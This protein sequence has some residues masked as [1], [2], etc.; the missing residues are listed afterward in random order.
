MH[1]RRFRKAFALLAPAVLPVIT[2]LFCTAHLV[3]AASTQPLS[4]LWFAGSVPDPT[5]TRAIS[6]LNW[7][8]TTDPDAAFN[9]GSVPLATRFYP[10]PVNPNAQNTSVGVDA[11]AVFG[12]ESQGNLSFKAYTPTYWQYTKQEVYWGGSSGSGN[13]L[14]P[15]GAVIDAAHRNGVPILGNVFLAPGVYGGTISQVNAMLQQKADGSFPVADKMVQ[16]AQYFHFDGWFFNQE[17]EGGNSATATKMAAFIQ[18]MHSKA[19]SLIVDWYDSMSSSGAISYQNSLDSA[20]QY[21]FQ[22]S[23]TTGTAVTAKVSDTMFLNYNWS[24]GGLASSATLANNLGRSRYNLFAGINTEGTGTSTSVNWAGLFPDGTG[25]SATASIGLYRPDQTYNYGTSGSTS[26]ARV[27]S[28][29]VSDS[30]YWVGA[31]ASASNTSTPVSG[32]TWNG[33]ANYVAP[34]SAAS[35]TTFATSFNTGQGSFYA[36]NGTTYSNAGFWSNLGLQ[37]VQPTWRWLMS[38]TGTALTPALDF[39]SAFF[40][41]TSLKV[42]GTTSA[43]NTLQLFATQIPVLAT[44]NF[45]IAFNDGVANNPTNLALALTF[46]DNTTATIPVGNTTTSTWNAAT[47]NLAAY[48]GKTVSAIGLQFNGSNSTL[49]NYT[50]NIGQ[51]AVFNGSQ[52]TPVAPTSIKQIGGGTTDA[53]TN[54]TVRLQ[55]TPSISGAYEYN[56]YQRRADNSLNWVGG[57]PE[58]SY[59][60]QDVIRD[61]TSNF[62]N[63]EVETVGNDFGVSSHATKTVYVDWTRSAQNLTWEANGTTAGGAGT[64]DTSAT[65]WFASSAPANQYWSNSWN[66]YAVFTGTGGAVNLASPVTAA[67]LVFSSTGY[68]ITGTNVLTFGGPTPA[69]SVAASSTAT[70]TAPISAGFTKVGAGTLI[71]PTANTFTTTTNINAGKIS[72]TNASALG[73]GNIN[74]SGGTLSLAVPLNSQVLNGFGSFTTTKGGSGD[75]PNTLGQVLT[76]TDGIG[77]ETNSAFTLNPVAIS[78][79]GFSAAFTYQNNTGADGV[80]F[81]IQNDPR[82]SAAIGGGG[83]SFGYT[84]TAGVGIANSG[85]VEFN[86]YTGA[87]VGTTFATNGAVATMRSTS[88]VNLTT[89]TDPIGVVLTYNGTLHTLLETLTDLTTNATFSTTYTG[90][91]FNTLLGGNSGYI[92]FTGAS[93]AITAT[94]TISNFS[95]NNIA[96]GPA[97][98]NNITTTANT[99]STIELPVSPGITSMSVGSI[100]INTLSVVHLTSTTT[101]PG[102]PA[103]LITSQLTVSNGTLDINSADLIVHNGDLAAITA[104]IKSGFNLA[105]NGYW[106][107][108]G[109]NSSS[110][111]ADP[112]RLTAIG[113]ILNNKNGS[114]VYG[115]GSTFDGTNPVLTDVLIKRT[116]YGDANLDGHVNGNDYTQIDNGFIAHL[117]GWIN[118]DFNYDGVIDGSDY[119]LIDNAFNTQTSGVIASS[120][121]QVAK[122]AAEVSSPTAVPEPG[123]LAL[124]LLSVGSVLCRNGTNRR[125]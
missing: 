63:L 78:P 45:K 58:S 81:T 119:S 57:T 122:V 27:N 118:G 108:T 71:I 82:G 117:S 55:W 109:I 1:T 43:T 69:V 67:G 36:V 62:V 34:A 95:F 16:A 110:S 24:S 114:V 75:G 100:S 107:G 59:F 66:D 41:G 29:Y 35:G 30:K 96:A 76:L 51:L 115:A 2:G 6:I 9:I 61:G 44:T 99:G 4:G 121:A 5:Q 10:T 23:G 53:T 11:L 56:V 80:T 49:T 98:T 64:W 73:T 42:S 17:T 19:P 72:I 111:A 37:D 22:K 13:I 102:T 104:L 39:T 125:R 15:N 120:A 38:S 91:N 32:T 88:P 101:T 90:V 20:N 48:A 93:G 21:A 83:G 40:G 70:I 68:N 12:S 97:I 33:I 79:T 86:I 92:G 47:F 113:V 18:Y 14:A 65:N 28:F 106:N 26:L 77:S 116:F 46:S 60:V 112:T 7:D 84:G 87:T 124:G 85:A 54:G 123:A 31:N 103:V 50:I 89:G 94:Q 3:D 8:P 25:N 74:L 52:S 105:A